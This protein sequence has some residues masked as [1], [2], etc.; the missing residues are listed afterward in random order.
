[1]HGEEQVKIWRRSYDVPPPS[2]AL[3]DPRHPANDP[4][5]GQVPSQALPAGESLALTV[6]RVLPAWNDS[7]SPMVSA[8]YE[9]L[10]VAHG[11]SL[12]ALCQHIEKMSE[13]EVLELN[14]PTGVPLV[15]ELDARMNFLRK[16]YL[17][18]ADQVAAKLAAVA[19]QGIAQVAPAPAPCRNFVSVGR[20]DL[21][22]IGC[23]PCGMEAAETAGCRGKNVVVIDP[24]AVL[25]CVP[26][27][28]HSKCLREAV[29]H[30]VKTWPE[31]EA[32]IATAMKNAA[33]EASRTCRTFQITAL[34]GYGNIIDDHQVL[35]K[36]VNGETQVLHTDAIIV[37]TGSKSNRFPPTDFSVPGVYDS[38]TIWQIDRIPITMVIQGAGIISVEYALIFAGLGTKV[39]ILDAFDAF[40][41]MLD[42]SMQQAVRQTL[43]DAGVQMFFNTPLKSVQAGENCT[44]E[45]PAVRVTT[46]SGDQYDC[47]VVLSACG[48]SGNTHN[49]G[50]EALAE[51]GLKVNRGRL[52]E[53]DANGYT[54]VAKV[55]AVGDCATGSMGLATVGQSQAVR[56]VRALFSSKGPGKDEEYKPSVIWTIPDLAWAGI[57]EEKVKADKINFGVV[58]VDFQ[59]TLRGCVSGQMGFMKL[60]FNRDSGV[61][62]GF[63]IFGENASEIINYGAE[64]VNQGTT[65]FEMLHFV[66][67]GVTY[68][69]LYSKAAAEAKLRLK[70]ARSLSAATAWKRMQTLLEESLQ[71]TGS[72]LTWHEALQREFKAIDTDGSGFISNGEL[73]AALSKLGLA[74][75]EDDAEAMILEASDG[76]SNNELDYHDFLRILEDDCGQVDTAQSELL[77]PATP[78]T[79][80]SS[81]IFQSQ[82]LF[83]EMEHL[84]NDDV[85]DLVVIGAGPAGLKAA[86]EASSRGKKVGL[87]ESAPEVT[88]ATNGAHSKMLREA[89]LHGAKTWPEVESILAAALKHTREAAAR[90]LRM[91]RI[92][93]LRGRGRIKADGTVLFEPSNPDEASREL[94]T[95]AILIATG[96]R[97][98][99][100]PHIDFSLPGVFDSDTIW[101]L[102]RLP[103]SL[104][105]EGAGFIGVEY[106]MIYARLGSRVTLVD[107]S[108][109][110]LPEVDSCLQEVAL[111]SLDAN[112]V[113]VILS[114]PIVS[115]EVGEG[116]SDE[117]PA[118][119][120][121]L[122]DRVL[123]CD[124]FVSCSARIGNT[125]SIG[126]ELLD[127]LGLKVS[128]GIGVIEVDK[129]GFT[130]CGKVY[131]AGDCASG[132]M[133]L[134]TVGQV[135]AMRAVR[136]IFSTHGGPGKGKKIKPAVIWSLPEMAWAGKSEEQARASGADCCIARV[137]YK[138]TFRGCITNQEGFMK[139]VFDSKTGKVLGVHIFGQTA[140]E[141][142][143]YGAELLNDG[144][145]IFRVL[146][147]VFP[148]VTYHQLYREAAAEAKVR[149]MG[150]CRDLAAGIAW[151]KFEGLLLKSLEE[152]NSL[153]SPGQLMKKAFRQF[154]SDHSGYL[155][156]ESLHKAVVSLGLNVTEE[157][158]QAMVEEATGDHHEDHVD[159]EHFLKMVTK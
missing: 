43:T 25:T 114:T 148:A 126:L 119:R 63:H 116:G 85:Y 57:T 141:I 60:I 58:T 76:A 134:A 17:M 104:V 146:H 124:A 56:A 147:F 156:K 36:G 27:G 132:S 40:L 82:M 145:T 45:T 98:L 128:S 127:P 8:G 144:L 23:G 110:F 61:A 30:G 103:G 136:K 95:E 99:R 159:Y 151:K 135:Q 44:P 10:V 149:M 21:V 42:S 47:E 32:V 12:R 24:A 48:R 111:K 51:Q 133:G 93:R 152:Q 89:V 157:D 22:V 11:N 59:N 131:A 70:G 38:D 68:H 19:A 91:F 121:N 106:A 129:N 41:P 107:T 112:G 71:L 26:T 64:A 83:A 140:G 102:K 54:G 28:A 2:V 122:G 143:N 75:S 35:F 88:G 79:A 65:I 105:L 62:L 46:A 81:T 87:L 96:S 14:I 158:V 72:R 50:L 3:D 49:I 55:F 31:V 155:T 137:N 4:L 74:C 109:S 92:Q 139:L 18:D 101:N 90:L 6:L 78:A 20:L 34:R 5:Y 125:G 13:E 37:A 16:F 53:V 115:I 153:S 66:H 117:V 108:A 69:T 15:Y 123:D 94:C 29:L 86:E 67:P 73:V 1:M 9:V 39:V 33:R 7:I 138:Q 97:A 154:D 77:L 52:V 150:G 120:V 100:P 130:G 113:K 80:R 118:L 142:I 84:G